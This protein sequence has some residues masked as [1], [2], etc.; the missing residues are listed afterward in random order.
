MPYRA[1]RVEEY[2]R[3]RLLDDVNPVHAASLALPGA[4]PI[5]GNGHKVTIAN[6]LVKQAIIRLLGKIAGGG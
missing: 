4:S 1:R 6:N 2:L 3:G 5:A